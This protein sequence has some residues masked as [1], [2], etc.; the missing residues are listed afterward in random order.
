MAI[1]RVSL[2]NQELR[3]FSHSLKIPLLC[4]AYTKEKVQFDVDIA[5]SPRV[6]PELMMTR[7]GGKLKVRNK[8]LLVPAAL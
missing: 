1:C 7:L 5:K 4:S 8:N 2:P 6:H 3:G